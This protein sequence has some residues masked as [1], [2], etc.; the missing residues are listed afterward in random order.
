M[1]KLPQEDVI[2]VLHSQ[3]LKPHFPSH[4]PPHPPPARRA[5]QLENSPPTEEISSQE[6]I[7]RRLHLHLTS[8]RLTSWEGEKVSLTPFHLLVGGATPPSGVLPSCAPSW[9]GMA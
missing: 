3:C 7:L 6:G 9:Q 1:T 4:R 5:A 2:Y 8:L